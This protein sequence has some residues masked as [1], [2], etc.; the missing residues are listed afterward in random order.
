MCPIGNKDVAPGV[1]GFEL[2]RESDLVLLYMWYNEPAH[3][4]VLS[5][6][7]YGF[8][9]VWEKRLAQNVKSLIKWA[10]VGE[11]RLLGRAAALHEPVQYVIYLIIDG[12]L[13]FTFVYYLNNPDEICEEK[14]NFVVCVCVCIYTHVINVE[15]DEEPN[16]A[17]RQPELLLNPSSPNPFVMC[18]MTKGAKKEGKRTRERLQTFHAVGALEQ[19]R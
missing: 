10:E 14:A 8:C 17:P 16:N 15:E 18:L 11:K 3:F 12:I 13:F 4:L 6:R 9:S 19:K 5:K 1:L 7:A 2:V